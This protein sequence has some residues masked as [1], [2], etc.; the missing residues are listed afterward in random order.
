[1]K[2]ECRL[3]IAVGAVL[4]L[5]LIQPALADVTN[6]TFDT[7]LSGWTVDPSNSVIPDSGAALFFQT[8]TDHSVLS[9]EFLIDPL[10][11]TLSLDVV[12][13][14]EGE[15]GAET[16]HFTA[17]LLDELDQPVAPISL[18]GY[19]ARLD[20]GTAGTFSDTFNV[21]VSSLIG[22]EVTLILDLFH[23][24]DDFETTAIV[25]NVSVSVVPVPGAVVLGSLG[26]G[27]AGWRLRK[28]RPI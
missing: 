2:K 24:D 28:R 25:D 12:M 9:Q 5:I 18:E 27:L 15:G 1:M 4:V 8:S 6:G 22:Q 7:D 14:V 21:P 26:L 20:G 11:L 13:N 16:D 17:K 3:S 23:D 19:F 10:S